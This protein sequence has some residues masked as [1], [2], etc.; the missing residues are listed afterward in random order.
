MV[1]LHKYEHFFKTIFEIQFSQTVLKT[2]PY[3]AGGL[4]Q[5]FMHA[6]A[7]IPAHIPLKD[8]F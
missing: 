2:F 8:E 5:G 1:S 7:L 6:D 4:K 3:N